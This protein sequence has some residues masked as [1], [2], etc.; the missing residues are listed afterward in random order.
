MHTTHKLDLLHHAEATPQW[1][2]RPCRRPAGSGTP[3]RMV[4]NSSQVAKQRA[5]ARRLAGS[6]GSRLLQHACGTPCSLRAPCLC[7][8]TAGSTAVATRSCGGGRR[9]GGGGGEVQEWQGWSPGEVPAQLAIM[10]SVQS[11]RRQSEQS[12]PSAHGG[13]LAAVLHRRLRH[14]EQRGGRSERGGGA[15]PAASAVLPPP[16][17]RRVHPWDA[18]LLA[19][20][21]QRWRTAST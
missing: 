13:E 21:S 19:A 20:N 12:G 7:T 3:R 1:W 2:R 4:T 16:H 6:A 9:G 8:P 14:L 15:L 11:V 10:G 18:A 5:N 17:V